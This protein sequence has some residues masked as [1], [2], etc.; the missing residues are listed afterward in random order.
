[1]PGGYNAGMNADLASDI[2]S[3]FSAQRVA[4]LCGPAA[5]DLAIRVV[6]QTGSTN[7][8]LLAAARTL[9]RPTLLWALSQT[10]GRGRAGRVWH[11]A[12][13]ATLTFS[14]AWKFAL[15]LQ[16][17][18]GLPLA[19]G[20]AVAE[21]LASCGVE[22]RLKWPNDILRD[23][24]KLGGIL[25]ETGAGDGG[26]ATWAVIGVGLNMILPTGLDAAL[27]GASAA[28]PELLDDRAR[29]VAAVATAVAATAAQF[30]QQ[31]FAL[32]APRWNALHGFAGRSVNILDHG[33]VVHHGCAIGV[34][35]SGR[36]LLDTAHGRIAV[37][38]GDV[39]LRAAQE[40]GQ[41]DAAAG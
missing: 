17:L 13:D 15:P 6:A 4:A 28:A 12:E 7:A 37:V 33:A 8:D 22:V 20:V 3:A 34:D 36:L 35:E 2:P 24:R 16:A 18:L 14:L 40:Q 9:E 30:A 1:M 5:A 21:A 38:A 29:A 27:A 25:V 41:G 32:F 31:G 39:S 19:V 10:A 23:G 11:A 26:R